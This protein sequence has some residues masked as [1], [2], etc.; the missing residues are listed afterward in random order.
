MP[1]IDKPTGRVVA[2]IVLLIVVA[3]ALRGYLPAHDRAA[4]AESGGNRAA[5][6][7]VIAALA[8]TIALLAVAVIARLR[9]PRA[10]A[11]SAGNLSD[12]LGTGRGR[13]K[14]R[15]LLIGL[16]VIV[17]WLLI[18]MLLSRLSVPHGGTPSAPP[19]EPTTS[20]SAHATA[21]PPQQQHP[22]NNTGDMV[23]ILLAA[24][25]PM[26]LI[27]V[28]GSAIMARRRWKASM[29]STIVDD[30]IECP[31]AP[32]RTESLVRAA[33]L[34]LAEIG[35]LNREPREAIIACYATMERELANVPGAAPQDFDTP[36]EVLVRAVEHHALHADHAVE[37]V[38]LFEEARFSPHVMNERHREVAVQV[39]QLVL[40]EL[41]SSV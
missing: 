11:P 15:V 41:R 33:E 19:P 34:G 10:V 9:D 21:P 23:G 39:L 36:T 4:H 14:W 27:I 13:P 20:Q 8:G 32:E 37:L 28:A 31:P 29:P 40:A 12:M 35:D 38:N 7:F 6:L 30:H 25:V 1:G 24:M 18:V 5:M 2:L 17:A 22:Q 26:L 16:G 3:A